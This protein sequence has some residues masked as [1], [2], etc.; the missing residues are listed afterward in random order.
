[1]EDKKE[2]TFPGL[3]TP[4][5]TVQTYILLVEGIVVADIVVEEPVQTCTLVELIVVRG[6]M[7]KSATVEL[8]LQKPVTSFIMHLYLYPF[9]VEVRLVNVNVALVT[10]E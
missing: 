9:T 4:F 3:V 6:E 1:M 2:F 5:G 7:V 8:S 10:P